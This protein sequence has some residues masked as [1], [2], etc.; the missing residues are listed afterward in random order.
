M[1]DVSLKTINERFLALM[2]KEVEERSAANTSS[3][4]N[5]SFS[6]GK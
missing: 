1:A 4:R 3:R 5:T 2:F 6:S